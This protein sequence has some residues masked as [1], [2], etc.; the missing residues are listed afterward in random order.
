MNAAR[1]DGRIRCLVSIAGASSAEEADGLGIPCLFL[2][3]TADLVVVSSLWCRPSYE[4]VSGRAV[5][6]SLKGAVHTTCMTQPRKVSG[7][8][9]AWF[10]AYLN[11]DAG[12]REVFTAGG[13]LSNDPAWRDFAEKN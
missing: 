7:Y 13:K 12:A 9:L 3:G 2:T 6:A 4:A 1:K 11:G 10:D 5:Y 8:A